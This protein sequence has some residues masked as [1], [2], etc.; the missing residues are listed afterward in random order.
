MTRAQ[1]IFFLLCLVTSLS[2]LYSNPLIPSYEIKTEDPRVIEAEKKTIQVTK[3]RIEK[4]ITYIEKI[5]KEI[6]SF[7]KKYK[8]KVHLHHTPAPDGDA[9][10]PGFKQL[11]EKRYTIL[12]FEGDKLNAIEI[13][14]KQSFLNVS[15]EYENKR[16]LFEPGQYDKMT[17]YTEG[18]NGKYVT[19]FNYF[20]IRNKTR[21]LKKIEKNLIESS[22][23][24][25][26]ILRKFEF[27]KSRRE[28]KQIELY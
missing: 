10:V 9:S 14:Y 13:G 15:W 11:I 21:I 7:D 16:L 1:K 18:T 8:K 12:N 24:L 28:K 5:H 17:I 20:E 4:K 19:D 27:I 25:E 22:Y 23:K 3:A 6:V 2:L 26:N